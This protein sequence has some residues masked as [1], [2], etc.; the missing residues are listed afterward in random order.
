MPWESRI[1]KQCDANGEPYLTANLRD[2]WTINN[3]GFKGRHFATYPIELPERCIKAGTSEFG[4]CANC[5]KPYER[6]Y[7]D[8]FELDES[9]PQSKRAMDIFRESD[10]TTD[11]LQAIRAVSITDTERSSTIS[12]G[13][14]SNTDEMIQLARDAKGV[15]GGYY[16]EFLLSRPKPEGWQKTCNCETDAIEPCL[17]LDPFLGSGTTILTALRLGRRA[18]GIE[19]NPEYAEMAKN[20]IID[21]APLF[22]SINEEHA[23]FNAVND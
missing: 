13:A 2:V 9:R 17:V 14:G 11:H 23:L 8:E 21:D 15:L 3:S 22:N 1:V 20:R 19:L 12:N 6:G 4:C 18:V 7:S 16:R 10:L 5:G